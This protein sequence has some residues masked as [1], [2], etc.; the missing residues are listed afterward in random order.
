MKTIT[1]SL[2]AFLELTL[3]KELKGIRDLPDQETGEILAQH[4]N[5]GTEYRVQFTDW[6]GSPLESP[7]L[8]DYP[9]WYN[10]STNWK[11]QKDRSEK[12][13]IARWILEANVKIVTRFIMQELQ[14]P[15]DPARSTAYALVS[16]KKF[17]NIRA[18][19]PERMP[20]LVT[21]EEELK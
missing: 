15:E 3:G 7:K 10:S 18:I 8:W 20:K 2:Q 14:F 13:R 21:K 11:L 17:G 16:K 12:E 1:V 9:L 19:C 5:K 6:D 4:F